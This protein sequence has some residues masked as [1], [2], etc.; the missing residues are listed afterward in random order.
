[1]AYKWR[2]LRHGMHQELFHLKWFLQLW[3]IL[4]FGTKGEL[5][6]ACCFG[7]M[8]ECDSERNSRT[9]RGVERSQE[10]WEV[11]RF[12]TFLWSVNRIFF[13]INLVV[14]FWIG[15]ISSNSGFLYAFFFGYVLVYSTI[16]LNQSS[17]SC[18]KN[19]YFMLW[20]PREHC[21][22]KCHT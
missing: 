20:H 19:I 15:V 8:W 10:V 1:M 6:H 12:N 2:I 21:N 3:S 18:T 16:S 5:W 22:H 4:L 17:I 11:V 7:I 9:F 14:F 13:I